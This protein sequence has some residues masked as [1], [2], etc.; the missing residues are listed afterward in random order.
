MKS[1]IPLDLHEAANI[2]RRRGDDE[3]IHLLNR[4]ITEVD[5][6]P[7]KQRCRT[8]RE[9]FKAGAR[10]SQGYTTEHGEYPQPER[11]DEAFREW[12]DEP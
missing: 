12:R 2:A 7:C 11:A 6:M 1:R 8:N 4:A 5:Q 10:W 9:A 3:L